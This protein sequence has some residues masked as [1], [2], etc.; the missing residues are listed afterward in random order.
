A[1]RH[2]LARRA[3][4]A[5]HRRLA[6]D[7]PHDRRRLPAAGRA[8]GVRVV[9]ESRRLR[10][11]G[12]RAVGADGRRVRVP[13]AGRVH[14]GRRPRPRCGLRRAG[15]VARHPGQQ[16]GR[17]VARGV[18]RVSRRRLGQGGGPQPEIPLL[19]DAGAR[20]EPARG[21]LARAPGQGDHGRLHRRYP[22]QP[23]GDLL[24]P[25]VQGR[26][27]PPHPP[28]G[29]AADFGQHLR[30]RHRPR[31]FPVR[32]EPGGA[33]PGGGG[34]RADSVAPGGRRR[35]HAGRSDL[36]GEPRG[37]LLRGNYDRGGRRHRLRQRAAV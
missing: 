1:A 12:G 7:R 28:H 37:R 6:R 33:R 5:R 2:L 30:H 16:R 21:G 4:R 11:D 14:G 31:R 15:R 8:P 24:L 18:R 26:A 19:P 22:P 32:H 34:R 9:A 27:D 13:A 25:G 10:P 23:A 36:P 17:G 20:P 29:R 35:G 3:Y